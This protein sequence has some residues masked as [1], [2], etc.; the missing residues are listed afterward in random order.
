MTLPTLNTEGW[1]IQDF[2]LMHE[3]L[4]NMEIMA[5][6]MLCRPK[7]M[8]DDDFIPGA[9]AIEAEL[10]RH[11][12]LQTLILKRI[13]TLNLTADE[14]KVRDRIRLRQLVNYPED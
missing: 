6:G 12:R 9:A 5:T 2:D 8:A 1:S 10:D 3:T 11:Y 4:V 14:Q 13:D 7:A